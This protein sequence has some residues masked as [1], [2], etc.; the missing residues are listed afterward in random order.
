MINEGRS[1]QSSPLFFCIALDQFFIN[2]SSYQRNCLFLQILWFCDFLLLLCSSI[3]A[4]ASSG[5]TTPHI[6]LNVYILKGKT[7]KFTFIICYRRICK[8]VKLCKLCNII[9]YFF[10]ICMENM[11][12]IL[13]HINSLYIFC[14]NISCN[15][16]SF[17]NDKNCFPLFL[18]H[19]QI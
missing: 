3:F 7:I 10:I 19:E 5:V 9:P 8:T 2:I 14:I 16:R 6:L 15:I 4:A 18:L 11:C 1:L 12:T 13:M 17:I